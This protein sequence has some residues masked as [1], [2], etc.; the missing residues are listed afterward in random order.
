MARYCRRRRYRA[1]DGVRAACYKACACGNPRVACRRVDLF[2][3]VD[4]RCQPDA[5]GRQYTR[6]R[7][8]GWRQWRPRICRRLARALER[9]A[10]AQRGTAEQ[11]DHASTHARGAALDRYPQDLCCP[12]RPNPQQ[13]QLQSRTGR[14]GHGQYGIQSHRRVARRGYDGCD[15]G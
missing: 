13:T 15:A 5:T 8:T 1:G 9:R 10:P 14:S 3:P 12:R 7:I 2:W 6:R 11:Y 4:V